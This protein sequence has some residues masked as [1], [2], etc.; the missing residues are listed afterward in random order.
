MHAF[1]LA[2][3]SQRDGNASNHKYRHLLR[4]LADIADTKD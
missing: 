1:P 3:S 2:T 4:Y